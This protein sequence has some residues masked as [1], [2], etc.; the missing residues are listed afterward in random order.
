MPAVAERAAAR[1]SAGIPSSPT[2]ISPWPRA[3]PCT[4]PARPSGFVETAPRRPCPASTDAEHRC[5]PAPGPV[6]DEAVRAVAEQT[7]LDEE[8][9]RSWRSGRSSTCCP[10]RWASSWWTPPSR[11]GKTTPS[12]RSTSST[13]STAQ[14]QLPFQAREVHAQHGCR[15]PGRDRDR[16]LGAGRRQPRARNCAP[17]TASTTQGRDQG[18][19]AVRPARRIARRHHHRRGRRRHGSPEG[20]GARPAAR[21]LRCR[22]GS[23]SCPRSRWPTQGQRRPAWP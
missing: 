5:R 2:R 3:L 10:R 19:G 6:T 18:P 14:T 16:D 21:S 11:A 17:T 4:R 12:R 9:V 20:G 8:Q 15:P 7:G 13:S 22:S 23:A 1:S